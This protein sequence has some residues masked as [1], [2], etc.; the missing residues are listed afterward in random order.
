[1]KPEDLLDVARIDRFY[2]QALK[3]LVGPGWWMA[4]IIR[5]A[6]IA[7]WVAMVLALG[8]LVAQALD[9]E[10]P[11]EVLSR[12]LLTEKIAAGDSV[13][14]R[15]HVRRD[16]TCRTESTWIFFDG[17]GEYRRFGPVGIEASGPLGPD[18]FV[19]SW[20]VPANAAPGAARLRLVTA[21]ECPTNLLHPLYPVTRVAPDI[22]FEILPRRGQGKG[23]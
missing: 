23:S 15:F 13:K 12:E 18:T 8:W 16:R 10:P 9:R 14:V 19:R 21:W 2:G 6:S 7:Y 5:V 3:A 1:M 4:T 11:V 22:D 20:T 17:Q